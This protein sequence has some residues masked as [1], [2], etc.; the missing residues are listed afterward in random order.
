[1]T[2]IAC[3]VMM[4]WTLSPITSSVADDANAHGKQSSINPEHSIY[5]F[6]IHD[7]ALMGTSFGTK[8][9][10]VEVASTPS[11]RAQGLM[12]R[13]SLAPFDGMLFVWQDRALRHFWMKD[14]PLSLDI[15]FFD[16]K[17]VLFHYEDRTTPFSERL[18]PSLMPAKYVLELPAGTRANWQFEI[19]D[20]IAPLF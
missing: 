11:Q 8:N 15:L 10:V 13:T 1:M 18:I 9:I 12:K 20:H 14:T 4:G 19:G 2:V 7:L 17:G 6:V 3:A 16:E 5:G